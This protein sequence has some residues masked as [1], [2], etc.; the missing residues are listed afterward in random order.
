MRLQ[1]VIFTTARIFAVLVT[2]AAVI[3]CTKTR[4]GCSNLESGQAMVI[5]IHHSRSPVQVT[6]HGP[7]PIHLMVDSQ[8]DKKDQLQIIP[9]SPATI[10]EFDVSNPSTVRLGNDPSS[11]AG[12][13]LSVIILD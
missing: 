5:S 8:G 3:G 9:G 4:I 11:G 1:H 7:A 13:A 10:I 6:N 2:C 12:T